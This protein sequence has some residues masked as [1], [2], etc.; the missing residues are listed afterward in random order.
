MGNAITK[1]YDFLNRLVKITDAAGHITSYQ[2]D[3]LNRPLSTID[4][5]GGSS[6]QQF[7]QDGNRV[8]L[9]DSNNNR[10]DFTFDGVGRLTSNTTVNAYSK[11]F[12]YN[13]QGLVER[14]IN[15]RGQEITYQ[16]D[17][18]GR[19]VNVIDPLGTVSY[20]Y[21]AN[22]NILSVSYNSE[23]S[24]REYDALNRLTKYTDINGDIIQFAYDELDNLITLTYPGGKQVH[25]G[26]DSAN[27]LTS[28]TDWAGRTTTYEYNANGTLVKV[29]R[30]D[31]TILTRNYDSAGKMIEQI[32]VDPYG[33]KINQF[34]YSYNSVGNIVYESSSASQQLDL[35]DSNMSYGRDN[36][37]INYNS[38]DISNDAD[39]NMIFGP[40]AHNMETYSWDAHNRLISVGDTSYTYDAEDNRVSVTDSVYQTQYVIN[41]NATLSQVL[42]KT[43]MLNNSQTFYVYG[44][45]LIGQENP[46]GS[47]QT[48]HYDLRGST[49]AL[50]DENG[51]VTDRFYYGPYGE[52]LSRDGVTSTPFLYNGQ[53]GVMTDANGLYYM[54]ARYY[55]PEIKRFVSQD[56]MLGNVQDIGSL[57]RY[58]YVKGQP[59]SLIDPLGLWYREIGLQGSVNWWVF[60][61]SAQISL[62]QEDTGEW[63]VFS[64][65]S[66]G[67]GAGLG[68]SGGITL[69][70][71]PTGKL[72][73]I[74]GLS[75]TT[76]G[77]V[78]MGLSGGYDIQVT[79]KGVVTHQIN[80]GIGFPALIPVPAEFHTDA[81]YTTRLGKKPVSS[82]K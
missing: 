66:T 57:N 72:E 27:R 78:S 48:Y 50:T 9:I 31:G 82:L 8:A 16:Y 62:A 51:N 60:H 70:Y 39:G 23:I 6:S 22:G 34:T 53:D 36:L 79:G 42:I 10:I 38:Q 33:N 58:A 65:I 13:S 77:S 49:V 56:I 2:Y 73:D 80:A 81:T 19:L 20:T 28:V 55:N 74:E 41:P 52:L 37:V 54:R 14:S 59:I 68:A 18:A 32:D 12:V 17:E 46:D 63:G 5:L 25:Y 61:G 30:P 44:L 45:G 1:D 15:G 76:G 29:L 3:E 40:L 69:G 43:D 24:S 47:Y 4:A 21:D 35:L 64:A 11:D 7:D 67:G 26:Y 75:S 71:S